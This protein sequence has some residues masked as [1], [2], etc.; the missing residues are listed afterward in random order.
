MNLSR[1][2]SY[3]ESITSSPRE[4]LF[5]NI[6]AY[7]ISQAIGVVTRLGIPTFLKKSPKTL[8]ELAELCETDTSNLGRLMYCMVNL[9]YFDLD[10]NEKFRLNQISELL[11]EDSEN[12]LA[13]YAIQSTF[14]WCWNPWVHLYSVVK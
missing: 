5:Y 11:S 7:R 1:K 3:L 12:S 6:S 14:D 13:A 9:G 4:F 8:L 2:I 10:E